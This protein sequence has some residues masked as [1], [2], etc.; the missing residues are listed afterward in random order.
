[1]SDWAPPVECPK[2]GSKDTRFLEPK[3]EASVYE[4]AGCGCRFEIIEE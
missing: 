3:Y 1:M 2:C 4:C